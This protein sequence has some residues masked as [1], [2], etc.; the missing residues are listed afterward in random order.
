LK[1]RKVA[2][3][4]R[5]SGMS[6][7]AQVKLVEA[8]LSGRDLGGYVFIDSRSEFIEEVHELGYDAALKRRVWLHSTADVIENVLDGQYDAGV[9]TLRG[10]EKHK[11]RGLVQIPGSEFERHPNPWV[12]RENLPVDAVRD[13]VE[14]MTAVRG[15]PFLL[16][17]PEHPS[18]FKHIPE[19]RYDAPNLEELRRIEGLFPVPATPRPTTHSPSNT[20]EPG[21]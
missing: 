13:F 18:G 3:G 16:Q 17:L 6:F 19:A 7:N 12:A 2:F 8:G 9:T 11:H 4:D 5:L 10:F 14:V 20:V 15:E 21:K 1:G